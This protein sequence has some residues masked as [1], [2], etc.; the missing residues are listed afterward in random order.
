MLSRRG[1][2]LTHQQ[3]QTISTLLLHFLQA[4]PIHHNK[5]QPKKTGDK[6]A[7]HGN[8]IAAADYKQLK[9]SKYASRQLPNFKHAYQPMIKTLQQK[10][11]QRFA[12]TPAIL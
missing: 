6:C 3:H 11:A 8:K 10:Q 4:K 1:A 12:I 7:E 9:L 5:H 2:R